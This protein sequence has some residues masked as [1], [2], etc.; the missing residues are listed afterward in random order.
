MKI[1]SY[2]FTLSLTSAISEGV[3]STP[4]PSRFTTGNDPALGGAQGRSGR[5]HKI[6]PIS[7]FDART[8]EPVVSCLLWTGSN[9]PFKDEAQTA[10]FKDPVRTA[11]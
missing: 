11:Q 1:Q 4:R 6:L 9:Y 10:L 5:L 2:G 7:E 8:V 3:W